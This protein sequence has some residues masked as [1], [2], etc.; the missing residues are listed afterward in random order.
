MKGVNS[1]CVW[2]SS[3]L[4]FLP[5]LMDQWGS[6]FPGL[7]PIS[8]HVYLCPSDF[9]LF[10]Y[11]SSQ[12]FSSVNLLPANLMADISQAIFPLWTHTGSY[13]S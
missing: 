5:R 4:L 6:G 7:V 3:L 9:I 8:L 11:I 10:D 13:P 1:A 12:F 2:Y